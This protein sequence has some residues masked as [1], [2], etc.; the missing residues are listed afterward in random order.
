[1]AYQIINTS[2]IEAGKPVKESIFSRIKNNLDEHEAAIQSLGAAVGQVTIFN[3][4]LK[5]QEIPVGAALWTWDVLGNSKNQG[6]SKNWVRAEGTGTWLDGTGATVNVPDARDRFLRVANTYA[7]VTVTDQEI[8]STKKPNASMIVTTSSISTT[9]SG[10]Q[11]GHV[12]KIYWSQFGVS[13]S[14][15]YYDQNGTAVEFDDSAATRKT[16]ANS[17]PTGLNVAFSNITYPDN[18]TDQAIATPTNSMYSALPSSKTTGHHTHTIA[19]THQGTVTSGGDAETRPKSHVLNLLFKKAYSWGSFR[20]LY[21]ASASFTLTTVNLTKMECGTAGGVLTVDLRKGNTA[22]LTAGT[23][24][25]SVLSSLPSITDDG[26]TNFV[27][28][29][30]TIKTDGSENVATNDWLWL[31]IT[32]KISGVS[33]FHIQ[34]VGV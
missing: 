17:N 28:D 19:H 6:L 10:S 32:S 22:T 8:D 26:T 3:Q 33:E 1:M 4:I 2:E 25:I 14:D 7:A 27:E 30:G 29:A 18:L 11:G 31:N 21:K 9:D 16:Y 24:D 20:L 5:F 15:L 12:H 23:G 13:G 34:V